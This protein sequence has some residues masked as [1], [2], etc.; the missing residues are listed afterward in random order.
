MIIVEHI[1][2]FFL[3]MT[4]LGELRASIPLAIT[5]YKI[6]WFEALIVS[7][8]GN[9][10]PVVAILFLLEHISKL[11]SSNWFSR[12][13][14]YFLRRSSKYKKYVNSY[15]I[16]GLIIL[17]AIPLPGTGG[18]TGAIVAFLLSMPKLTAIISILIGVTIAGIITTLV[19]MGIINL[20]I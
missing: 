5:I 4:P 6:H 14:N 19:S 2:T 3:S 12:F 9:M 18:W 13:I 20:I 16:I 10:I 7:I 1:Y 17:V 8:A 15:G 11:D